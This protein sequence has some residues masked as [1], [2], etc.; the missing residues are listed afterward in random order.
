MDRILVIGA[1]GQLGWATI[2]RLRAT[3]AQLR[4]LIRGPESAAR[5]SAI[6]IEPV[7]GDLTNP[8]SLIQACAGMTTVIA[9]ANVAL[10]TRPGDTFE[11]V[12]RHGYRS[13]IEAAKAARIR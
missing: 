10:P 12:E 8:E 4:V 2:R 11:A 6:G 7:L 13:L 5:F 3:G 9:T 1:T